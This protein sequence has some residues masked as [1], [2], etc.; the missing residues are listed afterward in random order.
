MVTW[1][2]QL[3]LLTQRKVLVTLSDGQCQL[4]KR[5]ELLLFADNEQRGRQT[6]CH[7]YEFLFIL[8]PVGHD[9]PS[10]PRIFKVICLCPYPFPSLQPALSQLKF[11]FLN[12]SSVCVISPL[13][14]PSCVS[15]RAA[16][17]KLRSAARVFGWWLSMVLTL[18]RFSTRDINH[19][20]TIFW[21]DVTQLPCHCTVV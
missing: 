7:V 14:C 16:V 9:S 19:I 17:L 2:E 15:Q 20:W 5:C 11:T 8:L 12:F 3:F 21:V 1:T 10:E 4:V 18:Q 13:S 6:C